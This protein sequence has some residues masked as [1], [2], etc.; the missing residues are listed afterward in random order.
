MKAWD[1]K[2]WGSPAR[3]KPAGWGVWRL[4]RHQWIRSILAPAAIAATLALGGCDTDGVVP[5]GRSLQPLSGAMQTEIEQKNM[6]KESPILV[7]LFKEESELEV[8]KED[9]TGKF[10]RLKTYPI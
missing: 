5:S 6:T 3:G 10:V 1:A 9:R 2:A 7:R 4:H 8:W